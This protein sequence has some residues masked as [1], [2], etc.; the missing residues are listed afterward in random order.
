MEYCRE[1]VPPVHVHS[2]HG[3]GL[4]YLRC[5]DSVETLNEYKSTLKLHIYLLFW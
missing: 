1:Y 3:N 5:W 2:Y 4:V